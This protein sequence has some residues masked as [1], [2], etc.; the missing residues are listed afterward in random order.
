MFAS[1]TP[2]IYSLNQLEADALASK[3]QASKSSK[4]AIA[5]IP[6][7]M[8]NTLLFPMRKEYSAKRIRSFGELQ[9]AA[10]VPDATAGSR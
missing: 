6:G 10:L 1:R 4:A 9:D 8:V 5:D 2:T 7:A 3:Q